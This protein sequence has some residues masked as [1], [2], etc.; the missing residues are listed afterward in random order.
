MDKEISF[1]FVFYILPFF[2]I[3]T[4]GIL[5]L[6]FQ[7]EM[8]DILEKE[9]LNKESHRT[10]IMTMAGFSFTGLLAMVVLDATRPQ[11]YQFT[12]YYLFMSFLGYIFA[13]N[14]QSYKAKRWQD[15]LATA[16]L[17]MASLCLILSIL[18]ILITN[19]F[20]PAFAYPLSI[21]VILIWL[22]DHGLRL[23][24]DSDYLKE[25]RKIKDDKN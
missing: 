11:G 12:I 18:S 4:R 22:I 17:D 23:K 24:F 15:Q 19:N 3:V 2:P 20:S 16:S 14:L 6:K 7:K 9:E 25:K 5:Y 1:K 13:L 10:Y 21:V 8:N